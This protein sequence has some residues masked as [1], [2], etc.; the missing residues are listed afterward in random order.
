MAEKPIEEILIDVLQGK[1][2]IILIESGKIERKICLKKAGNGK[3]HAETYA[4]YQTPQGRKVKREGFKNDPGESLADLA[5]Y[6]IG[7]VRSYDKQDP[8]FQLEQQD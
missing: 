8:G 4:S 1:P 6:A 5:L 3:F 7:I 2:R